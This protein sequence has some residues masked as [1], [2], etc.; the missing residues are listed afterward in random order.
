METVKT[1]YLGD[2]RTEAT[3]V[4][5]G[6]TIITDAPVDNQGKGEFFSPTDLLAT[7]L[8]SCMLTIM[9]IAARTHG[10]DIDGTHVSITKVMGT[11]PRRVVEV[12]VEL[13]FPRTYSE[14][15]KKIIE[16]SAKECPVANSLHPELKQTIVFNYKD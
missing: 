10:F 8:G 6:K 11:N 7:A 14:K 2:L 13:N 16:L 4:R 15:V 9:G 5:S 12:I 1:T 3:H